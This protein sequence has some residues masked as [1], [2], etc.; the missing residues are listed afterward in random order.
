MGYELAE[1]NPDDW[2]ILLQRMIVTDS[3]EDPLKLIKNL[4]GEKI[5]VREQYH[6]F[7]K[8]TGFRR[9]TF[10]KYRR[11]MNLAGVRQKSKSAQRA[12][13]R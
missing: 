13:K 8:A 5:S 6:R 9:R 3:P 12:R 7:E 10:F 4:A 11:E 2:K 1:H